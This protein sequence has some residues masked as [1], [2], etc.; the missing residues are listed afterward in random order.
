[1][2]HYRITKYN[3]IYRSD[4]GGY[5]NDEWICVSEIGHY[6]NGIQFTAQ[7]YFIMEDKYWETIKYLL[8]LC[9]I[10]TLKIRG[11]EKY[12]D[13]PR[14][15]TN[16]KFFDVSS[17]TNSNLNGKIISFP[18]IEMVLRLCLR[19]TIWYKLVSEN[20]SYVDF[21]YDYYMYFGTNIDHTI[22]FEKIPEGIFIEV[23]NNPH[24]IIDEEE[25]DEE[26]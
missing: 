1:M 7:E 9:G 14:F 12:R 17:I 8:E 13:I 23:N 15:F 16:N 21:G 3:P 19:K 22:D 18:E 26:D 20:G 24:S 2:Y 4:E 25:N 6:F 10:Q 11:L 5:A